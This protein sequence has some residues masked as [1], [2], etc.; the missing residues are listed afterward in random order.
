MGKK[1]R[2]GILGCGNIGT[3]HIMGIMESPDLEVG[4]LCDILPNKLADRQR[5]CGASDDMC[6]SDYVEMLDSGKIDAVSIC[7]PNA[8][9]FD[10]A[11]EVIKRGLPYALEKPPCSN[12]HQTAILLEETAKRNLLNMVCFS[13]RFK[14]AA[15]YA[16]DLILSG[17]LG[18]IY[19]ISAEYFQSWALPDQNGKLTELNWR[20]TKEMSVTGALG[21]LGSHMIDLCRFLTGSEFTR[22]AADLGTFVNKRP[23]LGGGPDADVTV[24]DYVNIVGQM[25][26]PIAANL[27][28]TRFAYARGNYQRVEVYGDNGAI[29][30]TLEENDA[31]E[32]NIGNSP[33]RNNHVFIG[34]PIPKKYYK[35]Q[36][37]SFAD[38]L[39]GRS[40]GLP[41]DIRDGWR[42]MRVVDGALA[43]A[44]SGVHS[45]I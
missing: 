44:V 31:L 22:V 9:H 40:D 6:Y 17:E 10:M 38:I 2:I 41:A 34:V 23:M 18:K 27:S 39:N 13:Y 19:H 12:E 36:M 45:N 8:L 4:A 14:A 29:R 37:Q 20:F 24:D 28:I 5:Q 42:A 7:T 3:M 35:T 33:M 43:S 11:M 1:H 16:R 15:R 25:E 32:V 30:Y 26:G 21:D